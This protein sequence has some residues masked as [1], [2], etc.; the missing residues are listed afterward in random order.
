VEPVE[1]H[2]HVPDV[3]F[4]GGDLDCGNGLLLLIRQ[5]IDPMARGGLLEIRSTE[6]S[7]DEELPAWC[8]LTS[9]ELVSFTRRGRERSF[10]AC[11][12]SLSERRALTTVT[13]VARP[14]VVS[15]TVLTV[16]PSPAPAPAIEP[17]SVMGIG[18][19][20]R[21]AWMRRALH[22]H[23]EGRLPEDDFQAAADDAARL[24]VA[25]QWEAGVHVVTDGEQRRD[26]YASFVGGRLENCQSIPLT[27]LLAL[28]DDLEIPSPP[29]PSRERSSRPSRGRPTSCARAADGH[30]DS[31]GGRWH[32]LR[33]SAGG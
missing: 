28:V 5:H 33:S 19:W 14:R 11:K 12:G 6:P 25:A 26:S 16:L 9:N 3:T 31:P 32:P 30:L 29:R 2:A 7:V 10:L 1:R 18:S 4:E 23:L 22:E 27:D 24:V 8:R 21:P 20:P 15:P 13:A 17:L